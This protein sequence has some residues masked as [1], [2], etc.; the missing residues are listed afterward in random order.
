MLSSDDSPT[1]QNT[2]PTAGRGRGGRGLYSPPLR[3]GQPP[4][5]SG[6]RNGRPYSRDG[7]IL[8]KCDDITS[9]A[10]SIVKSLEIPDDERREKEEFCRDLEE[11]V[12]KIRPSDS[13][14]STVLTI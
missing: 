11:I 14:L 1:Q 10:L 2:Y 6:N 8:D 7:P 3:R 13:S 4:Q 5:H 9:Y 12:R